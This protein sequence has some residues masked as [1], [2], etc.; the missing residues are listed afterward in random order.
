MAS[1]VDAI[2]PPYLSP[3]DD[4]KDDILELIDGHIHSGVKEFYEKYFFSKS[5]SLAA[6]KTIQAADP[7]LHD[8]YSSADWL[9]QCSQDNQG[10]YFCMVS[11][12]AD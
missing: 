7:K 5:W 10:V 3:D 8:Y 12:S 4:P 2:I 1:P 9:K 6:K 11:T